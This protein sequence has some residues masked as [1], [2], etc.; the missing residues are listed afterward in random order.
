MVQV[1]RIQGH[2]IYIVLYARLDNSDYQFYW[3]GL[4]GL[5]TNMPPPWLISI[6]VV[7]TLNI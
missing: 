4:Y 2:E 6:Q 7:G 3:G 1:S 5:Y